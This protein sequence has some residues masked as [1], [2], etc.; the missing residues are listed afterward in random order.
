MIDISELRVNRI[1]RTTK[2]FTVK[3]ITYYAQSEQLDRLT[4]RFGQEL[5]KLDRPQKL[6]LRVILCFYTLGRNWMGDGYSINDA[7]MEAL[8]PLVCEDEQIVECLEIL[9]GIT[10]RDAESLL[11]A[12]SAQLRQTLVRGK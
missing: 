2:D 12:L 5:D 4:E 6:Q 1:S 7:W 9:G 8:Q 11:E 3:P 10:M